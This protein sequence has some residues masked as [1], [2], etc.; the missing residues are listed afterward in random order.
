MNP[1]AASI[2]FLGDS[3]C[4]EISDHS[5]YLNGNQM[6][7]CARCTGIFVGLVIG[8]LIAVVF[9]PKVRLFILGLAVLP[10]LIDGGLQLVTTYQSTNPLRMATGLLAGIAASLYLSRMASIALRPRRSEGHETS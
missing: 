5:Y 3:F 10:I 4:T 6:P 7:F 2:Y 1:F 9:D 8:M